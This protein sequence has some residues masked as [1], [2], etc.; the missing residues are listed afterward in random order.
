MVIV[1]VGLVSVRNLFTYQQKIALVTSHSSSAGV[2][3]DNTRSTNQ[4]VMD[5]T[6]ADINLTV[7]E[8]S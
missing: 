8:S 2:D 1:L 5:D 7:L 6:N 4:I 3:E